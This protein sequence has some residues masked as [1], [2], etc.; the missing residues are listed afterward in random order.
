MD[1]LSQF[2]FPGHADVGMNEVREVEHSQQRLVWSIG[3]DTGMVRC[4]LLLAVPQ[5]HQF[6]YIYR[7]LF[8]L[9]VY[10]S[11]KDTPITPPHAHPAFERDATGH[12]CARGIRNTTRYRRAALPHR[13][14]TILTWCRIEPTPII[15]SRPMLQRLGFCSRG[16]FSRAGKLDA[17][18]TF[19]LGQARVR[20]DVAI[21]RGGARARPPGAAGRAP[22]RERHGARD[23]TEGE[24]T[25]ERIRK[26]LQC[27]ATEGGQ[28]AERIRKTLPNGPPNEHDTAPR[29]AG[30]RACERVIMCHTFVCF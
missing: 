26:A 19:W 29:C 12:T 3:N 24:I 23:A 25:G 13:R 10:H 15:A 6:Q 8:N 4:T 14:R 16:S 27:D 11:D 2:Q 7:F 30:S 9:I 17:G 28:M 22:D 1:M 18:S 5:C 20:Y 21:W